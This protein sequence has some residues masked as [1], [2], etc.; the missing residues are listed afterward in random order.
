MDPRNVQNMPKNSYFLS[1]GIWGSSTNP[2]WGSPCIYP[3]FAEIRVLFLI[4]LKMPKISI[5]YI[6]IKEI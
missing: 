2:S 4:S 5:F 1:T 6:Y 3:Y